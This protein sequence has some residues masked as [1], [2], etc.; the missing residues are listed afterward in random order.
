MLM[1][2]KTMFDQYHCIVILSLEKCAKTLRKVNF[3]ITIMGRKS[4]KDS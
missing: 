2:Q 1:Y 3:C 4:M